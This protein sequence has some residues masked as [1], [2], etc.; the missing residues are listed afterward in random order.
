V[1]QLSSFP[2]SCLLS[3]RREGE[4]MKRDSGE[5]GGKGGREEGERTWGESCVGGGGG[6]RVEREEEEGR[7]K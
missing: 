4:E 6:G 5:G 3:P 2:S 7:W 1:V